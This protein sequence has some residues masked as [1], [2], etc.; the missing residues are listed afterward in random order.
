MLNVRPA[1]CLLRSDLFAKGERQDTTSISIAYTH[2]IADSRLDAAAIDYIDAGKAFFGCSFHY[3]VMV[4]GTIEIGRDPK[5]MSARGR[6][7]IRRQDTLFIGVVGG[8]HHDTGQRLD[9]MT[10]AQREALADL[11]Q[12]ISNTLQKELDVIDHTIEWTGRAKIEDAQD[13]QEVALEA[14]LDRIE[15]ASI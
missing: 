10:E 9:T 2:T 5:T 4:D 11:E 13:A 1:A 7:S 12:A 6:S 8:L 3:V 15:Q 14:E